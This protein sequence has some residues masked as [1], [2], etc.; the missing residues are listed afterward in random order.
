MV[1]FVILAPFWLKGEI[2]E[3]I[4]SLAKRT[5]AKISVAVRPGCGGAILRL[6]HTWLSLQEKWRH[7]NSSRD[8]SRNNQKTYREEIATILARQQSIFGVTAMVLLL[9]P[10]MLL[11]RLGEKS[12]QRSFSILRAVKN[13]IRQ[14]FG[15]LKAHVMGFMHEV[16][17]ESYVSEFKH[18][19]D[20]ANK[21]LNIDC[22]FVLNVIHPGMKYLNGPVVSLFADFVPATCPTGFPEWAVRLDKD[23]IKKA[24]PYVTRYITLSDHVRH[25]HAE[26]LFAIAPEKLV[27]IHHA[28]IDLSPSLPLYKLGAPRTT[29]SR[30]K[31]AQI[32]RDYCGTKLWKTDSLARRLL[33]EYLADFPFEEVDYVFVST[34]NRPYKN[35]DRVAE[36]VAR[37]LRRDFVDLK[38]V[39]TC[40]MDIFSG[41]GLGHFVG[42]NFL[43]HDILSIPRVPREVHAALYHCA[44]VT[45]HP[46]FFEGG[47]N[48]FTFYESL[49][50][51]TPVLL[52][53]NAATREA[54][55]GPDFDAL[56]F[57]PY[58]VEEMAD[59]IRQTIAERDAVFARQWQIY[60]R[61]A[62]RRNWGD[63]ARDYAEVF[64]SA[65]T[66]MESREKSSLRGFLKQVA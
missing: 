22:W 8:I 9:S 55:D 13:R 58:S 36:A 56:M 43:H 50:L 2:E 27:T 54:S 6:A 35:I 65:A 14:R 31:A 59:M 53:R 34:Q 49:S 5:P 33:Q 66:G 61:H 17:R 26:K 20:Y 48:S 21:S 23:R 46:S 39:V 16:I 63:V 45:V 42:S 28:P 25:E 1:E 11:A 7:R 52:S 32:I 12:K 60:E 57:D 24:M 38:M 44:A 4:R 19:V 62:A 15:Y 47:T 3:D 41:A 30:A 10:F 29:E 18:M 37:L 51:G 40:Q 64:R